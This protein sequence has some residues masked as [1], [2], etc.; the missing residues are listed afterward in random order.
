MAANTNPIF[1]LTPFVSGSTLM[2]VDSTNK[3]TIYI[4]G[5]PSGGRIDCISICS[6][7]ASSQN[8]AFY[9][10]N[11]IDDLYIGNVNIPSGSG[12][13]TIPKVDGMANLRPA[14]QTFIQMAAGYSLK[15][16]SVTAVTSGSTISIITIG[17]NF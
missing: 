2:N 12:Y 4:A 13:T 16:N 10:N 6:N 17:G 1:E 14:A 11:S 8:L 15:V 5:S 9:I 7:D 3:K